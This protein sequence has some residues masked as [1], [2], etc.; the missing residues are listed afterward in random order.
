MKI[1]ATAGT[2]RATRQAGFK[3]AS[4]DYDE[5]STAYVVDYVGATS[6]G[7]CSRPD[8]VRAINRMADRFSEV[9]EDPAKFVIV[10]MN[11]DLQAGME[12]ITK[13]DSS[14][15]E[16]SVGSFYRNE[17]LLSHFNDSV[18][19]AGLPHIL[20]FRDRYQE[21][22]LGITIRSERDLVTNVL[23]GESIGDWIKE[24]VPLQ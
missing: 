1:A 12:F 9:H 22:D 5:S 7:I 11:R 15:D 24:D 21:T 16:L 4:G 17:T 13:Y 8:V 14:W 6:C 23:G 19:L 10:A 3:R 20:V 2:P 18:R